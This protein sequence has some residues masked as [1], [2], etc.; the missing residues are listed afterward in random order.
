[1][2]RLLTVSLDES[3]KKLIEKKMLKLVDLYY[4]A[5]DA[6]KMGNKVNFNLGLTHCLLQM[7][8]HGTEIL[9]NL[10]FHLVF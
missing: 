5:L 6:P 10:C 2:D 1:M 9:I 3:E 4:L 8:L 7:L